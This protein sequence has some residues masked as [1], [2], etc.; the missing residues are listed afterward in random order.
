VSKSLKILVVRFSSIGDIVLTT[1]VIR[2]LKKQ[3]NAEV[4]YLTKN[5]YSSLLKNNPNIDQ[6][7]S[8]KNSIL[9]VRKDL[10][11]QKYDFIIDLHNNLRSSLL[12]FLGSPVKRYVKS[13]FKKFLFRNFGINFLKNKHVVDR[14]LD[15]ISFLNIK[16]DEK[17]LEYYIDDQASVDFDLNQ[18]YIA[19][20]I[21]GS[22]IQKKISANQITKISERLNFPIVLI[23]GEE[24]KPTG[25]L[26]KENCKELVIKNFCG[27]LDL[28][29][30]AL[31]I[32]HSF[33]LFSNDTGMMHIGAALNKKIVSFWG[34][35]K[36]DMGFYPYV[37]EEKSLLIVSP[38][39]KRQCSKHGDS[40]RYSKDGCIKLIEI[41]ENLIKKILRFI[42]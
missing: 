33:C 38:N 42:S 37:N 36:P 32:E 5:V 24:E 20:A 28:D 30:S 17:G 7:F 8:I 23:G 4:H 22:Q 25:D 9:E 6:L 41:D 15:T 18:K 14:Y 3:L 1:P 35:T 27:V 31:I 12:I 2:V 10:K 16:N 40:C 13:N 21:G 11:D 34:C 29:Q 39:S 19:W 26:I